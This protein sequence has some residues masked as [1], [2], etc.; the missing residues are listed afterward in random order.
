MKVQ[1]N[2]YLFYKEGI[3][4][5]LYVDDYYIFRTSREKINE[6]IKSLEKPKSAAAKK[7]YRF[8]NGGFDFIVETSIEKFLGVEVSQGE[9]IVTLRQ[10]LLI[11]RI[12]KAVGFENK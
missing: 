3:V 6:F 9:N 4:L 5:I 1:I 8:K 7:N 12:I 10:L 11:E 2:P